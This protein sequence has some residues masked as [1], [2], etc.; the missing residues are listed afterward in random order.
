MMAT[1][2]FNELR[3]V[4]ELRFTGIGKVL[5][6]FTGKNFEAKSCESG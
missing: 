6:L 2:A 3:L 4:V 5:L 1:M